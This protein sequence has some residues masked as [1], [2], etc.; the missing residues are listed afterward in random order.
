M[1][2]IGVEEK[3]L[4]SRTTSSFYQGM[5]KPFKKIASSETSRPPTGD[6]AFPTIVA[7]ST[8]KLE[9]ADMFLPCHYFTYVGGTSTGWYV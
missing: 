3:L 6:S 5:Y 9:E 8:E 4:D 1:R 7:E 2:H